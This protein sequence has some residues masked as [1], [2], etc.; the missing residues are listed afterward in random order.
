MFSAIVVASGALGGGLSA[1]ITGGDIWMG[2]IQGAIVAGLNH[3]AHS[4]SD[5]IEDKDGKIV[6]DEDVTSATDSDLDEGETYLGKAVVHFQGSVNEKL[7]ADGTLFGK[8]SN[9]ARVTIYGPKGANDIK[10]YNG[11]SISSDSNK[12]SMIE[13]GDYE[14]RWQQMATSPYGKGSLTYRIHNLNGS[15]RIRPVGGVNKYNGKSYMEGI[16]LHRTNW[17]GK[18]THSS[19]GCLNICGTQWGSVQSQLGKLSSFRIRVSR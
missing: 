17:S 5:W 16:F 7:G 12:Y 11:L 15:T 19:Q 4:P 6:W 13:A 1:G 10:T 18:A 8:G 2:A 3:V 9:P 14:G